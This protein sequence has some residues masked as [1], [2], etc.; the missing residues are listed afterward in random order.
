MRKIP[1]IQLISW[2]EHFVEAH[3]FWANQPKHCRNCAFPQNFNTRKLCEI[4]VFYAVVCNNIQLVH[5]FC[6][7]VIIYKVEIYCSKIPPP[8]TLLRNFWRITILTGILGILASI[9]SQS[10]NLRTP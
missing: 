6:I 3:S 2:W 10:L 5:S 8:F 4:S 9:S 7:I 1:K